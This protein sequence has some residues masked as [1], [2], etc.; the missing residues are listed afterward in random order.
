[1]AK[2]AV[3]GMTVVAEGK[4]LTRRDNSESE[5][6]IFLILLSLFRMATGT[7][8]IDEALSE[9]EIRIGILVAVNAG[10]LALMV[11]I[12]G[13]LFRID[14][15]RPNLSIGRNLSYLKF[16]MAGETVLV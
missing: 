4:F 8:N 2:N 13:P 11:D 7:V 6:D 9:M 15:E 1:M 10:Q 14:I 5:M 3:F 16:A 12:L